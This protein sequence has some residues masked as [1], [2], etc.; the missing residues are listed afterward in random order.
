VQETLRVTAV[1]KDS[2][3]GPSGNGKCPYDPTAVY[4]FTFVSK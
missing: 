2:Y 4:A 3:E 1:E